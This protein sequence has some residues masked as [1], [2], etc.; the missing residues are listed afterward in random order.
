MASHGMK[1]AMPWALSKLQR[2]ASR[3]LTGHDGG[4]LYLL[5]TAVCDSVRTA[6]LARGAQV[7][8]H[9]SHAYLD[10]VSLYFTFAMRAS[11]GDE[12][13]FNLWSDVLRASIRA[14]RNV[15]HHHGT[16]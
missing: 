5:R 11:A 15:T 10:G 4:R 6:T 7:L 2:D 14:G 16:L 13:Y 8:C 3:R 12:S 1:S 9:F